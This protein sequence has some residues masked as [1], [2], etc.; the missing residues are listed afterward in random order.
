M[1][2][3]PLESGTFIHITI[4]VLSKIIIGLTKRDIFIK[5]DE[6]LLYQPFSHY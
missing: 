1:E 4:Y 6:N 2:Q 5:L 3:I